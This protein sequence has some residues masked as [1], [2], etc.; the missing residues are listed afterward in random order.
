LLSLYKDIEVVAEAENGEEVVHA[1][2]Y[3]SPSAI[4]MDI[5]MPKLNGI[6][7]TRAITAHYPHVAVVGVSAHADR[8][9]QAAMVEAGAKSV[10]AKE[11]AGLLLYGQ[12][13][14]GVENLPPM[15]NAA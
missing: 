11:M 10:V 7:A 1:M 5:N 6:E 13:K 2:P 8:F 14:A 12:I 9:Y 15:P 4:V 3:V